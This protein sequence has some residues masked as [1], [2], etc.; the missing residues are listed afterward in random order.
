[1][2]Y[3]VIL[4]GLFIVVLILIIGL[5]INKPEPRQDG[6]LFTN[7]AV[8]FHQSGFFEMEK[9]IIKELNSKGNNQNSNYW[10]QIG[11]T[12]HHLP[13]ALPLIADFYKTLLNSQGPR[14]TFII[15]GPD[16]F[17]RCQTPVATTNNSYI[18]PFGQLEI[19]KSI[20]KELLNT[21]VNINSQCLD[22]EHSI[23]V[24]TIFI[25][26]LFP[27]A[28]IVPLIFSATTEDDIINKIVNV[29]LEHK[30]RITIIASVDFS[31]Y[32]S[33]DQAV[34]L[35]NISEEMIK[36]LDSSSFTLRYTDSPGSLKL[37][38]LLAE[39]IGSDSP[40][41]LNKSNSYNL[42]D[43]FENTTGYMN[44]LFIRVD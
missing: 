37:V 4:L 1:M 30:D 3:R 12:S 38:I 23:K 44:I 20:V 35:D 13:T 31:H 16:H 15:L 42:T 14:E 41:V 2:R 10:T 21:G 34:Q 24:Q 9:D 33:Y 43:Q 17:E 25:K 32:Y 27:E 36:K 8:N 22:K 5:R 19:D 29:L 7:S 40:I 18:T 6:V 28:K 11:I 39:K 26:Y